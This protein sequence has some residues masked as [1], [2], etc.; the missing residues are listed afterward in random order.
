MLGG[1]LEKAFN[2]ISATSKPERHSTWLA[3]K[4]AAIRKTKEN[5]HRRV[6]EKSWLGAAKAVVLRAN[7]D[8]A[9]ASD[10]QAAMLVA[11]SPK[12][13]MRKIFHE[14][15]MEDLLPIFRDE[16][17]ADEVRFA[18]TGKAT[19]KM[20]SRRLGTRDA[21]WGLT[22][23]A[24]EEA[25]EAEEEGKKR[26]LTEEELMQ[27]GLVSPP[28]P[29]I[30]DR[31]PE[32]SMAHIMQAG[33]R[34]QFALPA[35]KAPQVQYTQFDPS[36]PRMSRSARASPRDWRLQ[37]QQQRGQQ[38]QYPYE[39]DNDGSASRQAAHTAPGGR[40]G[41]QKKSRRVGFRR[42]LA[43][44]RKQRR[45][46]LLSP[47]SA[48]RKIQQLERGRQAREAMHILWEYHDAATKIAAVARG[49]E[50]RLDFLDQRTAAVQIQAQWRGR[51]ARARHPALEAGRR[52]LRVLRKQETSRPASN[53]D[54]YLETSRYSSRGHAATGIQ[55]VVRGRQARL[56]NVRRFEEHAAAVRIQAIARG[57]EARLDFADQRAAAVQIQAQVRGKAVR[58][59]YP[60]LQPSREESKKSKTLMS[61]DD[62]GAALV[63]RDGVMDAE[64]Y[65]EA[66]SE[67]QAPE[68]AQVQE[69]EEDMLLGLR[70]IESH[71]D[72]GSV[73]LQA[74]A[75]SEEDSEEDSD[76]F[77]DL[78]DDFHD[79]DDDGHEAEV[80]QVGEF[81]GGRVLD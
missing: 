49:R 11:M 56:R 26:Q 6:K 75:D 16:L 68:Q 1:V 51:A 79:V 55:R 45:V 69:P 7:E 27:I 62:E 48:A 34:L 18:L 23:D 72:S 73:Q 64:T 46:A 12:K 59:K 21:K 67:A 43:E 74:Q 44:L 71:E 52:R 33:Y 53:Q 76:D 63:I 66:L 40:R 14:D 31:L 60:G 37:Q 38:L 65:A 19:K 61:A 35:E 78:D 50:A 25:E 22:G 28:R 77:H 17:T 70:D 15:Q 39:H 5:R 58:T 8:A 36:P 54:L 57:K 4:R 13:N 80:W 24:E 30:P 42:K 81:E 29:A 2:P 3:A 47:D 10:L 20:L 9:C 41:Y 32:S